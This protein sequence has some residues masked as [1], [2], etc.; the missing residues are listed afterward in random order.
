MVLYRHTGDRRFLEPIERALTWLNRSKL[1]DGQLARFYE[2]K[3]NKPL[4][5]TKNY[6]LTYDDSDLP[7]HYG[8]KVG[9]GNL[10]KLRS[11]Y[12]QL[13]S[14]KLIDKPTVKRPKP[15]KMSAEIA[16]T[17]EKVAKQMDDRGAWVE[18]GRL[19]N[20]GEKDSTQR[21]ITSKT[22]IKN[23]RDLARCASA[24]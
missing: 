7:T 16:R 24:K 18:D 8:F 2:L 5:F 10:D 19:K 6:E 11:E 1:P 12:A 15:E 21:I 3:T 23:L 20:Y 4:Y 13:V 14:A 17:A 9:S 22:F